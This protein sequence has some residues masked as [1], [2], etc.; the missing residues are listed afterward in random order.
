MFKQSVLLP[1]RFLFT[2]RFLRA[3]FNQTHLDT[4]LHMRPVKPVN[5]LVI[6]EHKKACPKARFIR[7]QAACN[8]FFAGKRRCFLVTVM[9]GFVRAFFRHVDVSCL[10]IRQHGQFRTDAFQMQTRHHFI[11]MLG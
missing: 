9:V 3:V 1:T 2:G 6:F 8:T 4:I 11:Q 5:L 10:L 7:L